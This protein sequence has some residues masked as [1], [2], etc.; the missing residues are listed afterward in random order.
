MGR[1]TELA[2][3]PLV[4]IGLGWLIDQW[5]GT[6]PIATLVVAFIGITGT[7]VKV[8]YGYDNDMRAA[9]AGKPWTRRST[10]TDQHDGT[11]AT[12]EHDDGTAAGP[13]IGGAA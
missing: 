13:A 7:F 2:I 12:T 1:G 9:E 11:P 4:F 6:R 8:W 10:P 3:T 5:L